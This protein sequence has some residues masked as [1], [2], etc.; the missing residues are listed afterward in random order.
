MRSLFIK[1]RKN[2]LIENVMRIKLLQSIIGDD[3]DEDDDRMDHFDK[4]WTSVFK[5][6]T[7]FIGELEFSDLPIDSSDSLAFFNF[8]FLI[9]FV[10]ITIVVLMNLLN[11]LAVSDV[12]ELLAEAE[13][14]SIKSRS[15]TAL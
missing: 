10:F 12:G 15:S 4:P 5:T 1:G 6:F 2:S 13:I 14:I 7:M 3:S 11:G 8:T 9:L